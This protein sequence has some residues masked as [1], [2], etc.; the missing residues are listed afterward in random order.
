IGARTRD[1]LKVKCAKRQEFVIGGRSEPAGARFGFGALLLGVYAGERLL[2][3]GRV[4]T[5][6]DGEL[7]DSIYKQLKRIEIT[8]SAFV[9][10]PRGAEARGVHW[11]K[12]ELVCEVSFTEWLDD[13]SPR[14]P[15][16]QGMREDKPAKKVT[17][18]RAQH[19]QN[20]AE[21]EPAHTRL[22]RVQ[23]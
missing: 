15:S 16:F 14:H 23:V 7:L 20:V 21:N 2:Y 3:S 12:P 8:K 9:D 1:W 4:G 11:V 22:H 6:F 10:P 19:T 17:R 18:E 5:G 13:H